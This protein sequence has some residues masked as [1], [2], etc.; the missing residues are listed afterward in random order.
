MNGKWLKII[1]AASLA[2]NLAAALPFAYHKLFKEKKKEP[3]IQKTLEKL[4]TMPKTPLREE[5]KNQLAKI[6][7]EF[8]LNQLKYKQDIQEKRMEIIEELG[9]P[10]FDPEVVTTYAEELNELENQLNLQ[11]VENLVQVSAVLDPDQRLQFLYRMSRSWFFL[12]RAKSRGG[13]GRHPG[14][15]SI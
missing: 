1:L 13:R 14:R 11:F 5:Q 15:R 2:L 9:A 7:R 4:Q 6:I 10:E 12:D 3:K 8:R